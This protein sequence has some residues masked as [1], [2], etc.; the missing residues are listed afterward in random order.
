VRVVAAL[1][2]VVVNVALGWA[3]ADRAL[4]K[5]DPPP[6]GECVTVSISPPPPT[7][8][9]PSVTVCQP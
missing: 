5:G 7:E 4:A 1:V 3:G 9:R 2:F 6:I 8:L